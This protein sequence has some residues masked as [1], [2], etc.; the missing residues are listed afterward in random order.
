M[1]K[2]LYYKEDYNMYIMLCNSIYIITHIHIFTWVYLFLYFM[3][4]F[5]DVVFLHVPKI[6]IKV[7][8]Q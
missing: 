7:Q 2:K 4:S 8:Q 3:N 1:K 5:V 6:Q